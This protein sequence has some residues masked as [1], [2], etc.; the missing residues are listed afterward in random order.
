MSHKVPQSHNGR[1]GEDKI[2]LANAGV[3]GTVGVEPRAHQRSFY[4]P[5]SVP[6]SGC[7]QRSDPNP[8]WLVA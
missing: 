6:E 7:A 3:L 1:R 2:V 5:A 8:L 4:L